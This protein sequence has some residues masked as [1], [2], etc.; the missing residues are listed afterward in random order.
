MEACPSPDAVS[1]MEFVSWAAPCLR[2]AGFRPRALSPPSAPARAED[3]TLTPT[4]GA[5]KR[6]DQCAERRLPFQRS[7]GK[8]V[9]CERQKRQKTRKDVRP[10][11]KLGRAG[12][13]E[14][15]S[16][17]EAGTRA[18]FAGGKRAPGGAA[19]VSVRVAL[20]PLIERGRAAS[21]E[22]R[23]DEHVEEQRPRE[24]PIR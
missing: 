9:A 11:R 14:Q 6:A 12:G 17:D 19:H 1:V 13:G 10:Q 21:D 24:R 7:V 2:Q 8:Q 22:K 4:P 18:H 15:Q 5:A 16:E 23:S 20:Y 3:R